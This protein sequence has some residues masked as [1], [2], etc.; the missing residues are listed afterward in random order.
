MYPRPIAAHSAVSVVVS[1]YQGC[2]NHAA[3]EIWNQRSTSK[4]SACTTMYAAS[5][6]VMPRSA[7]QP[8]KVR[9]RPAIG[10]AARIRTTALA[11][12]ELSRGVACVQTWET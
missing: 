11:K 1:T 10:Q 4:D 6:V 7:G 8:A 12:V 9:S 3:P 5:T 2:A